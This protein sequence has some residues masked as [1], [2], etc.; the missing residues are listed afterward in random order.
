MAPSMYANKARPP[1]T[2]TGSER[3]ALLELTGQTSATYRDHMIF[4]VALGTGLREA[5]LA[6]LNVGDVLDTSRRARERFELRVFKRCSERPACQEV[7]PPPVL[8][9]KLERFARWKRRRGEL[10]AAD[11]PLFVARGGKRIALRTLRYTFARWRKLA[12]LSPGLSF[13]ALRHTFCQALY[14]QTGDLRLVQR[15]ARHVNISTTTIY[16]APSRDMIEA[17][18]RNLEC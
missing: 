11:A 2:L 3:S 5:E 17:A 1:R 4:A 15:A 13:H 10:L 7:F 14:E 18:I 9:S 12:G 6:G 16:A 8:R